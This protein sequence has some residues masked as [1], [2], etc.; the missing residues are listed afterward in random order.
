MIRQKGYLKKSLIVDVVDISRIMKLSK[1]IITYSYF[2]LLVTIVVFLNAF[3]FSIYAVS[4]T[5]MNNCLFEGD[6]VM[7]LKY[8]AGKVQINEIV[9]FHDRNTTYIKRCIGTP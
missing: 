5:S 6:R 7:V 1:E 9:V 3:V 4:S 8:R 2:L